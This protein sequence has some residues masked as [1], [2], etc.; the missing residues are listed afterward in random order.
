MTEKIIIIGSGPAGWA[1]A[2][3]AARANLNPLVFEGALTHENQLR[4][5][6]PLGQLARTTDVENYPGFPKAIMGPELMTA[7]R[8]QAVHHGTRVITEDI[9]SIDLQRRPFHMVDSAG[10]AFTAHSVVIATG[11]SANYLGLESEEKFKNHGV[12]A[13]AVCDGALP[14]FR[15]KPLVVVG[16]GDSAAEEGIYLS[17]FASV[18][19]LVHRRENLR[20]CRLMS[21]RLLSH[22]KVQP[23]WNSAVQE[24]MG[25]DENGVTAVRVKNLKTGDTHTLPASGM[26][27]AIGH[28]PNTGFLKNQLATDPHGFIVLKDSARTVTSVEGVFAAGDVADPIYKQAI[29]AAGMGCKAALD[30]ER[31]LAT[32]G[33]E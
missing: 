21:R 32:Q 12:S 29:T 20:A 28:T 6:L 18:L 17:K 16:G 15:N 33:I 25:D 27:V 2:I 13:C 22:E 4:G 1:A 23:L 3:Y 11:A 26:F 5:T 10:A 14:R 8:E 19:Y 9:V 31:W 30:A 7:M 24:V